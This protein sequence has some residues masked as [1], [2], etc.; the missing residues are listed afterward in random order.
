MYLINM[1]HIA[2]HLSDIISVLFCKLIDVG[3]L[4]LFQQYIC[5]MTKMLDN[6]YRVH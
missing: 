6:A 2:E 4:W 5:Y 1:E 3:M